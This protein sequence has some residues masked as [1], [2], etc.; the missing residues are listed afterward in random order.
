M[1]RAVE[2]VPKFRDEVLKDFMA[3]STK[4]VAGADLL[5]E[6]LENNDPDPQE[7]CGLL[8]DRYELYALTVPN[9]AQLA[10]V[11]T[12][13]TAKRRPW[14][15]ILHGLL[16]HRGRPCDKGRQRAVKHLNLIDPTWEPADA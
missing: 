11:V 14:P 1:P 3:P 10:L 4:C 2:P 5:L 16:S 13:D 12:L 7:R 6:E 8:G 9:C 15:C